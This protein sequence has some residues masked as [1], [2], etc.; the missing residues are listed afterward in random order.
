MLST[1]IIV[2]NAKSRR[3]AVVRS[4]TATP[5]TSGT[6][7]RH[8][9]VVALKPKVVG[10]AAPLVISGTVLRTDNVALRHCSK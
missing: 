6:D 8:I 10:F 2:V 9:V 4:C 1:V 5:N 7:P 3:S